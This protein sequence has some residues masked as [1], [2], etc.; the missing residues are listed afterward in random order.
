MFSGLVNS[1]FC[2]TILVLSRA[3]FAEPCRLFLHSKFDS[4]NVR[5]LLLDKGFDLIADKAWQ[6]TKRELGDLA[7]LPAG[8]YLRPTLFVALKDGKL[9][10]Y[11]EI[12]NQFHNLPSCSGRSRLMTQAYFHIRLGEKARRR[13]DDFYLRRASILGMGDLLLETEALLRFGPSGFELEADKYKRIYAGLVA[14]VREIWE[15]SSNIAFESR[16]DRVRKYLSPYV[17]NYFLHNNHLSGLLDYPHKGNCVAS[18]SLYTALF[19]DADLNLGP[20]HVFAIQLFQDHVQPVIWYKKT[21]KLVALVSGSVESLRAPIYNP[22]LVTWALANAARRAV[23]Q[24]REYYLKIRGMSAKFADPKLVLQY[25]VGFKNEG[26]AGGHSPYLRFGSAF[27]LFDLTGKTVVNAR[28]PFVEFGSRNHQTLESINQAPQA[29]DND[30]EPGGNDNPSDEREVIAKIY[31]ASVWANV[32]ADQRPSKAMQLH[33]TRRQIVFLPKAEKKVFKV[34]PIP[35]IRLAKPQE[36]EEFDLDLPFLIKSYWAPSSRKSQIKGV[37]VIFQDI[38]QE[39]VF[40]NLADLKLAIPEGYKSFPHLPKYLRDEL[41]QAL[42][43]L[44]R[45]GRNMRALVQFVS[46]FTERKINEDYSQVLQDLNWLRRVRRI[47]D[48]VSANLSLAEINLIGLSDVSEV[49]EKNGY[50][51]MKEKLA[52]LY[53]AGV[54]QPQ[55]YISWLESLIPQTVALQTRTMIE[56]IEGL[57]FGNDTRFLCQQSADK[58]HGSSFPLLPLLNSLI[59]NYELDKTSK[60]RPPLTMIEVSVVTMEN[61]AEHSNPNVKAEFPSAKSSYRQNRFDVRTDTLVHLLM[62][63]PLPVLRHPAVQLAAFVWWTSQAQASFEN[64]WTDSSI[65]YRNYLELWKNGPTVMIP[66]WSFGGYGRAWREFSRAHGE[67]ILGN[68]FKPLHKL[69]PTVAGYVSSKM[70]LGKQT[71]SKPTVKIIQRSEQDFAALSSAKCTI[72][73]SIEIGPFAGLE[74][75]KRLAYSHWSITSEIENDC[76]GDHVGGKRRPGLI[77]GSLVIEAT[78]QNP[79]GNKIQIRGFKVRVERPD[80]LILLQLQRLDDKELLIKEEDR[81]KL[82]QLFRASGSVRVI[83]SNGANKKQ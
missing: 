18:T 55:S 22:E 44:K 82:E 26:T 59:V 62:A 75:A 24:E 63:Q 54:A 64:Y 4:P 47:F 68:E 46:N 53:R 11:V 48:F 76:E 52:N 13:L 35:F 67:T 38:R 65:G 79:I 80:E 81:Q 66:Q 83:K 17:E 2:L 8:L 78:Q 77:D 72:G 43:S 23:H 30:E 33:L 56:L 21:D 7:I 70:N 50:C 19:V 73:E 49:L 10:E 71:F 37:E 45:D 1:I 41:L 57:D 3:A 74:L 20:D 51:S 9:D 58:Y 69:P 15:Q 12:A 5:K 14:R 40:R 36:I 61:S 25:A 42:S 60:A 39:V 6:G 29:S 28:Q 31:N 32:P 34:T 27:S 16:I